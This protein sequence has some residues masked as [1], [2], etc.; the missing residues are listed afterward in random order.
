MSEEMECPGCGE[1]FDSYEL[2]EFETSYMGLNPDAYGSE[3]AEPK[4]LVSEFRVQKI[5]NPI[6]KSIWNNKDEGEPEIPIEESHTLQLLLDDNDWDRVE[7]LY[8]NIDISQWREPPEG[9]NTEELKQKTIN[10]MVDMGYTEESAE[11]ATIRV[12][13][14]TPPNFDND[15]D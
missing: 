14:V 8:E 2:R 12:F 9:S 3:N 10:N 6:N 13:E 15:G 7:Q 1:E 4:K 5:I 11:R